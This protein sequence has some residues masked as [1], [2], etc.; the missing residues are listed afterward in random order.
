MRY[1]KGAGGGDG[2]AATRVNITLAKLTN[3]A[4]NG[5]YARGNYQS[6]QAVGFNASIYVRINAYTRGSRNRARATNEM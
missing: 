6:C 3:R 1:T 2:R 4:R 5:F